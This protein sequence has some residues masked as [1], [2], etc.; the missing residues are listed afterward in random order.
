MIHQDVEAVLFPI[1]ISNEQLVQNMAERLR[2]DI[3]SIRVALWPPKVEELKQE[4]LPPLIIKLLSALKKE[5]ARFIPK[6]TG[7]YFPYNSVCSP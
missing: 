5:R 2:K 3:D 7:S 6:H 4:E 1:G